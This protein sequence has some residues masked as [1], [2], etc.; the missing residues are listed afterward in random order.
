MLY[1]ECMKNMILHCHHDVIKKYVFPYLINLCKDNTV[2][3]VIKMFDI[4][5]ILN[6]IIN[7]SNIF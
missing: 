2:N 3:V 5:P 7:S 1:I 4:I 6:N